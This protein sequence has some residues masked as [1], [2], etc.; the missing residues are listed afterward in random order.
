MPAPFTSFGT[1]T[2]NTYTLLV[3]LGILSGAGVALWRLRERVKLGAVMDC[4]IA[5]LIGGVICAR[6]FHIALNWPYFTDHTAEI[7]HLRAGGLSW[8]GAVIGTLLLIVIGAKI[9]RIS[10]SLLVESLT[11]ALALIAFFAWWGCGAAKCAY[12]AEVTNLAD[13]PAWL[14]L[15]APD[16]FNIIAPRYRTQALGMMFALFLLIL[17]AILGW[18]GWLAGGRFWLMLAL[19]SL[20]MFFLGFLRGDEALIRRG[21][22]A[23]Q[24][25]DAGFVIIGTTGFIISILE[26]ARLKTEVV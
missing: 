16:I 1:F 25:L 19:L 20:G 6:L 26:S 21:L 17:S 23:D 5:G 12:G 10:F 8:H 4:L 11:P 15:E 9:R 24:W 13:Y 14:V 7:T 2:M 18:R 22:R 3:A